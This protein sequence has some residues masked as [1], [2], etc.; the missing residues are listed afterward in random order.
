MITG[1]KNSEAMNKVST[2]EYYSGILTEARGIFQEYGVKDFQTALQVLTVR[3]IQKASERQNE[4]FE[5][6]LEKFDR[7]TAANSAGE[8][9]EIEQPRRGKPR[10][11]E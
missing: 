2:K 6:L 9:S 7:F 11:T 8:Q 3:E 10:K 5:S 4:L 1:P